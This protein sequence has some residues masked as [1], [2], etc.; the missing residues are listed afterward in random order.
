MNAVPEMDV[1]ELADRLKSGDAFVLL[2]VRELWELESAAL[3]DHRLKIVPT[4][5][6]V[7]EQAASVADLPKDAEILVL[8]HHG[9]RSAN[10]T[11]W[12][13]A[14]GWQKV[15]SIRGG[16]HDYALQVDRSVGMY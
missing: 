8:C 4:S 7:Q 3:R 13:L 11:R 15:Y 5:R 2:D 14:Q 16:I 12:L 6:M 9:V 1:L 10:V